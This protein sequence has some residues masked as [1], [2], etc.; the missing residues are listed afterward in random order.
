MCRFVIYKGKRILLADILSKPEHSLISQASRRDA[1]TPG[2]ETSENYNPRHTTKRNHS[3]NADGFGLAYFD[4]KGPSRRTHASLFKSVTP[5]WSDTNLAELLEVMR[6]DLVFAH[7]RAASHLSPVNLQNCHPFRRGKLVFMHNGGISGFKKIRRKMLDELPDTIYSC[8]RG[9]TDSELAFA[10]F[11]SQFPPEDVDGPA[12]IPD[13]RAAIG[14]GNRRLSWEQMVRG[15]RNTIL[16]IME[17]QKNAGMS[18]LEAASSLNFAVSDG[19]TTVVTR[20]R[21]HP[22][23]DPPTLYYCCSENTSVVI[24]DNPFEEEEED[25]KEGCQSQCSSRSSS[26]DSASD[27][28]SIVKSRSSKNAALNIR[29][30]K[31]SSSTFDLNADVI[32]ASSTCYSP[33]KNVV[34]LMDSPPSSP[35]LGEGKTALREHKGKGSGSPLSERVDE[36]R[37]ERWNED[38]SQDNNDTDNG[39]NGRGSCEREGT[40]MPRKTQKS[41]SRC[42]CCPAF[43]IASEPLDYTEKWTLLPKD[44][45]LIL[46]CHNN[47]RVYPLELPSWDEVGN[48]M[49]TPSMTPAILPQEESAL[50]YD[51]LD[52]NASSCSVS[53]SGKDDT[54]SGARSSTFRTSRCISDPHKSELP[55]VEGSVG[56]VER[57]RTGRERV[58][59]SSSTPNL[60]SAP[61]FDGR[62]SSLGSSLSTGGRRSSTESTWSGI[63]ESSSGDVLG[64]LRSEEAAPSSPR[65][66]QVSVSGKKKF[67]KRRRG[68]QGAFSLKSYGSEEDLTRSAGTSAGSST[69][70]QVN[71]SKVADLRGSGSFSSPSVSSNSNPDY[72]TGRSRRMGRRSRNGK[73]YRADGKRTDAERKNHSERPQL[74]W[75]SRILGYIP[76]P[77]TYSFGRIIA[78][79]LISSAFSFVAGYFVHHWLGNGGSHGRHV[80]GT[81]GS[82]AAGLRSDNDPMSMDGE[83][84]ASVDGAIRR[85]SSKPMSLR[86]TV[87][88]PADSAEDISGASF[89]RANYPKSG[90]LS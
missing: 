45:I 80:I 50:T 2:V 90:S 42:S 19:Q 39:K 73:A 21:T 17:L 37:E 89:D 49:L 46:D 56:E 70:S 83:L 10:L 53:S 54:A 87:T 16:N 31:S 69:S 8:V 43:V 51:A 40:K 75:F 58:R 88:R 32:Q 71:G 57:E 61:V 63:S 9:T 65:G 85:T 15:M 4:T 18:H 52:L 20:C 41:A 28:A 33:T 29:C 44:S 78:Q 77:T 6:G 3:V 36:I 72:R 55:D 12:T 62:R 24:D 38:M 86:R 22:E 30:K 1:Y 34:R 67:L 81:G 84:S 48:V 66:H 79:C 25:Y 76:I 82:A 27:F 68:T 23:H 26:R 59:L 7:I 5:A 60:K 35:T 74:P 13:M 47:L 64:L 14:S 11:L